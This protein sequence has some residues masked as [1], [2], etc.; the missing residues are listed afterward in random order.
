MC[1]FKSFLSE[2]AEDKVKTVPF[3]ARVETF[4]DSIELYTDVAGRVDLGMGCTFGIDWRQGM[5]SETRLFTNG[6][7]PNITLLELLAIMAMV[8]TWVPELARKRIVLCTDNAATVAFIN[9]MK[10]DIPA[11]MDLLRLVSKTCLKFQI[12]L[13]AVHIEGLQNID[14]DQISRG[15]LDLF[16]KWNLTAART[17]TALPSSI[18]PPTWTQTQMTTYY[19][20]VKTL[21]SMR[22]SM[23][24]RQVNHKTAVQV[25][26]VLHEMGVND[27]IAFVA[28]WPRA[29]FCAIENYISACIEF[30][31]PFPL[32]DEQISAFLDKL[33]EAFYVASTL[34][35]QWGT[36]KKVCHELKFPILQKHDIHYKAVK[37]DCREVKDN[38]LLVSQELLVQLCETALVL[39]TGYSA[40]LARAIF[41][42]AWAFSMRICEYCNVWK[43]LTDKFEENHNLRAS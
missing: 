8:E 21:T 24:L 26:T 17:K 29:K 1:V 43:K 31:L 23:G 35:A 27:V 34:E 9:R 39:F 12:W 14:C 42:S 18:W 10:A 11:A 3:L 4:N 2:G 28:D 6:F 37:S 30:N 16:F 36:L 15:R 38:K 32:G 7:H 40:C 20:L 5:W 22:H 25:F 13:K 33:D 19:T 41:I